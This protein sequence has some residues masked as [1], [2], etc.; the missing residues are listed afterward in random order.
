MTLNPF[1]ISGGINIPKYILLLLLAAAFALSGCATEKKARTIIRKND[2][3]CDLTRL[4]RNKLYYSP[5]YKRHLVN[6]I[7]EIGR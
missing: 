2:T 7:R 5:W 4:G 1:H 6:N 3:S